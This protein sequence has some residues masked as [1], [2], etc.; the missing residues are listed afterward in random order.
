M[1]STY[2]K[3]QLVQSEVHKLFD[4]PQNHQIFKDKSSPPV[5]LQ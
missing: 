4:Y 5:L 3:T 1:I 2:H